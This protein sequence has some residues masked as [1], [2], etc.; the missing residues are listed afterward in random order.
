LDDPVWEVRHAAARALVDLGHPGH[1]VLLRA[2][3]KAKPER[4]REIELAME[5]P[6]PW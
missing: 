5:D 2:R 3:A 6:A 1:E 4:R